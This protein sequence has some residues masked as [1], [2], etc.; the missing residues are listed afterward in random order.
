MCSVLTS[1]NLRA[2]VDGV[3]SN[4]MMN[5]VTFALGCGLF[6]HRDHQ[7][8]AEEILL[9]H[10]NENENAEAWICENCQHELEASFDICWK[11]Q[12]SRPETDQQQ[13]STKKQIQS[14]AISDFYSAEGSENDGSATFSDNPFEPPSAE[15]QT[16]RIEPDD[17]PTGPNPEA[18]DL[19]RRAW[20]AAVLGLVF[21]PVITQTYSMYLLL[22]ASNMT[23][24]FSK[25]GSRRFFGALI[26][27]LI[28]FVGWVGF[29]AYMK[30]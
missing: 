15:T 21:L 17:V 20:I 5:H 25:K 2:F 28:Y 26:V 30:S 16:E 18:E 9:A 3:G 11:C 10:E 22:K 7:S 23:T 29:V 24:E 27:N 1:N 8:Q 4:T 12:K 19:L 13:E 14:K 6:V